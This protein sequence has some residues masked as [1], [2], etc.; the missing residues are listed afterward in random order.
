MKQ[1]KIESSN[2]PQGFQTAIT[3]QNSNSH[4]AALEEPVVERLLFVALRVS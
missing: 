4:N 3:V 1:N 2:W